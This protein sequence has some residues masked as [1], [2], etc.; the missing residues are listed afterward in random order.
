VEGANLF[1]TKEA[2]QAL[3]EHSG[4][5]CIK[6]SSAN[7][8]G[9]ICS[10]YEI[11][12]SMVLSREEFL[13]LKDVL[14]EDVLH[15][16]RGT[17]R[18][19]AE[20]LWREFRRTGSTEALPLLSERVS[21]AINS[22]G[23]SILRHLEATPSSAGSELLQRALVRSHMPN[24]LKD[25]AMERLDN[26]VPPA[27]VQS[28]IA[29]RLASKLVYQEGLQYV[30]SFDHSMLGELAFKYLEREYEIAKITQ[31]VKDS[32]IPYA[33]EVAALLEHG[34]VRTAVE[35]SSRD[36]T[37]AAASESKTRK[38]RALE[39]THSWIA[40]SS[41]DAVSATKDGTRTRPE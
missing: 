23:L 2:R 18:M 12:A 19:E 25:L 13:E 3:F 8:C 34:G 15:K 26:R 31:S 36:T 28:I 10:S 33:H 27:Y 16:M 21:A 1:I 17:A 11:L 9:V 38:K 7:K 35:I 41:L 40:V 29:S 30:E 20:L 5:Y 37:E 4:V 32:G 24:C 14:V 39:R 22:T 6:D